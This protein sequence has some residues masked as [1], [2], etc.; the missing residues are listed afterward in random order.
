LFSVT[1]QCNK[2]RRANEISRTYGW[3]AAS[4]EKFSPADATA[5]E[6]RDT[7]RTVAACPAALDRSAQG[8]AATIRSGA[9][10]ALDMVY[11]AGEELALVDAQLRALDVSTEQGA[12]A[13]LALWAHRAEVER[14]MRAHSA[15]LGYR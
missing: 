8:T 10:R 6:E 12:R 14:M 5:G 15:L 9:V 2:V 1:V 4:R 3:H 13:Q 11:L 7:M